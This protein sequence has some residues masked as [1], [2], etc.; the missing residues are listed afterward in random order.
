MMEERTFA[1]FRTIGRDLFL[2]GLISSHAGNMSIRLDDDLCVTRTGSMLGRLTP[3][4]LVE[5]HLDSADARDTRASSELIVHRAVYRATSAR[6]V[7][8]AHPPYA[9]LLSMVSDEIVPVDT[10]GRHYFPKVPVAAVTD[11]I[12]SAE[13][14]RAVGE[15]LADNRIMV[16]RG[17]GSFARGNTLEEAYM[18]TSS[19][20]AAAFYLYHLV[21]SG[22]SGKLFR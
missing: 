1:M 13:G 2:R 6:A 9:T 12:G 20:E 11:A 7:V 18:L 22:Q 15:R 19:L 17:H 16:M 21:L 10:E 4:D 5:V 3:D 14:A 8:H